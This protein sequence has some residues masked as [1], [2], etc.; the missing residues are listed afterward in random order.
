MIEDPLIEDLE[1]ELVQAMAADVADLP[2][3]NL[4]LHRMHLQH[5]P[6]RRLLVPGVAVGVAVAVAAPVAAARTGA[7]HSRPVANPAGTG[8]GQPGT[9]GLGTPASVL[10]S[11]SGLPPAPSLPG[12]PVPL[13]TIAPSG[14]GAPDLP[15][16][17][18][19]LR[20]ALTADE[21]AAAVRRVRAVFA[22]LARTELGTGPRRALA[23]LS[24]ADLQ[25]LLPPAGGL[26][27]YYDCAPGRVLDAD[28]RAAAIAEVRRAVTDAQALL[29]A[30]KTGIERALGAGKVPNWLGDLAIHVVSRNAATMV[31]RIDLET[32]LPQW[33]ASGSITVTFRLADHTVVNIRPTDLKL[34]PHLPVP[35][36]P[37]PLPTVPIP[38]PLPSLAPGLGLP[39]GGR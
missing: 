38:V 18:T 31:L 30:A 15:D 36:L 29:L 25:R 6:A 14:S 23:A 2:A 21:Y 5:R 26:V 9:P 35:Q 13:P 16:T 33:P 22:D 32:P 20:R 10:P 17:C 7:F 27:T 12:G 11:L 1:R 3:P 34:P 39:T 8:S 19:A 4:N 28:Q 24:A 37:I